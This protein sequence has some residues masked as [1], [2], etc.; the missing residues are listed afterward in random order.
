MERITVSHLKRRIALL[1]DIFGYP[2]DAWSGERDSRGGLVASVGTYVLDRANGGYRLCQ[3][4]GPNGGERD[5]TP[6]GTARETYDA[7]NAFIDGADAM[8]RH[9]KA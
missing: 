2:Q 9:M 1:N 5:I 6:R 7:I 4:C 3:M 8:R